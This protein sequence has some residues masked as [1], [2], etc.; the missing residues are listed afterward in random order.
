MELIQPEMHLAPADG[1]P[2]LPQTSAPSLSHPTEEIEIPVLIIGGGPAGLSAAQNWGRLGIHALLVDDKHRLGGKLVLQ[3]HRFFGSTN[4]VY[5]G[6]RGIDI[7]TRLEKELRKYPS[8][9]IW[10]QC[11]ALAV[12]SDQKVGILRNGR[13]MFWSSRKSCWSR[14]ARAKNSWPLKVIP[15][16]GVYGAG[17]FQTLVNRDLVRPAR[18]AV[19]RRRRQCGSD[20]RLPCTAGR[21]RCGWPGGSSA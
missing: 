8:I 17:A 5:A 6:T 1:L 7:A 9:N 3:T 15:L 11:T 2:T 4:A 13:I 10:L 21:D 18:T 19:H 16:P 20:R 14:P 12:F